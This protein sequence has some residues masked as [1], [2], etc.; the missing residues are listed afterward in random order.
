MAVK[1]DHLKRNLFS[2]TRKLT[3]KPED[4][5]T[6]FIA[7]ALEA[8]EDFRAAYGA[9]V[10]APL[11][12]PDGV[13]ETVSVVSGRDGTS[14]AAGFA[15]ASSSWVSRRPIRTSAPVAG[16]GRGGAPDAEA[17]VVGG[18]GSPFTARPEG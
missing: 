8:D 1:P 5:L 10:L 18:D 11:A 4:H 2:N 16:R 14:S 6:Y 15:R 13:L 7:A 9:C 17:A 3:R 12:G